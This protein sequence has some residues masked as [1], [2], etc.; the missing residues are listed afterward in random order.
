MSDQPAYVIN[1]LRAILKPKGL[2]F[3]SSP[4][5]FTVPDFLPRRVVRRAQWFAAVLS[6]IFA[7]LSN[8]LAAHRGLEAVDFLLY[9]TSGRAT[10]T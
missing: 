10:V 4:S 3:W 6:L 2:L 7:A 5:T 8:S 9:D 1:F